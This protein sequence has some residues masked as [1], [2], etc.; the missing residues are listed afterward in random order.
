MIKRINNTKTIAA[1]D[2][3]VLQHIS[4]ASFFSFHII[5]WKKRICV[6]T[7][8]YLLYFFIIFDIIIYVY[9]EGRLYE[10]ENNRR[11]FSS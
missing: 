3:P 9:D 5:L 7:L 8:R 10:K 6:N 2:T 11:P 4:H 1:L